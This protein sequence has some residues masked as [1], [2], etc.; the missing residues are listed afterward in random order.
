MNVAL[1]V[2]VKA[3]VYGFYT[4]SLYLIEKVISTCKF[5]LYLGRR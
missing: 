4:S 5:Q 2:H 1:L 3:K